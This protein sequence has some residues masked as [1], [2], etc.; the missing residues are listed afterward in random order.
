MLV[1]LNAYY[2][3]GNDRAR[4]DWDAGTSLPPHLHGWSVLYLAV[5]SSIGGNLMGINPWVEWTPRW[6]ASRDLAVV[7]PLRYLDAQVDLPDL[8]Y[9]GRRGQVLGGVRLEAKLAG[10]LRPWLNTAS[11]GADYVRRT[12]G[13]PYPRPLAF[14]ASITPLLGKLRITA[15]GRPHGI[16]FSGERGGILWLFGVGDLNGD[17]YWLSKSLF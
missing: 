9:A 14:H 6:H 4:K 1:A 7:L 16:P 13:R 10:V 12:A 8:A 11:V 15:Q 2:F 17:L 5:P 3:A